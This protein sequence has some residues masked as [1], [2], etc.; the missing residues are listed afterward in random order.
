MLTRLG[1]N[2][3]GFCDGSLAAEFLKKSTETINLIVCDVR[4][5]VMD[6]VA[7]Y[8]WLA[9]NKPQML[10]NF[11]FHSSSDDILDSNEDV[12][13]VPRLEKPSNTKNFM[14]FVAAHINK[15]SEAVPSPPQ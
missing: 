1:Y 5:A 15:E 10:R 13:M 6:G 9:E 14:D 4:M 3:I 7:F 2:V 8:R 11:M 12:R